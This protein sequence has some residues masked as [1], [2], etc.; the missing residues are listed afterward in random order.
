M[1]EAPGSHGHATKVAPAPGGP[2]HPSRIPVPEWFGSP[3]AL[4]RQL[5]RMDISEQPWM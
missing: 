2:V 5:A 4:Y 1:P 3:A